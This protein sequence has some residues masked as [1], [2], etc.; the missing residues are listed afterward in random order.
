MKLA[1][2]ILAIFA[3]ACG[4]SAYAQD[5]QPSLGD[6]ARAARK[7]KEK[8]AATPK[9]VLTDDDVSSGS[10]KGLSGLGEASGSP[11]GGDANPMA[12]GLAAVN[13]VEEILDKLD[14]MDR[15]TLAKAALLD[16]D[17]DFPDRAAWESKL[18]AAK[19]Q[20]VSHG[21]ELV[22]QMRQILSE[23][24]SLKSTQ[25]AQAKLSPQDPRA[26]E[27]IHRLQELVQD[28][29]RTDTA[30]QAVVMEGWDRA[31]QAKH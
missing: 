24:Q 19:Q 26:Q 20:Y 23:A 3:L 27:L 21:R 2:W 17:V 22:T 12:K 25:S 14:P 4:T 7:D 28:A 18:Y 16:N 1:R 8:N 30:Y 15:G 13:K 11:A 31:K 10:G 5:P 6:V 9:K 29:V